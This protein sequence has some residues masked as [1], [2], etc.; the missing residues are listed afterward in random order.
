M[1]NCTNPYTCFDKNIAII[2]GLSTGAQVHS[3]VRTLKSRNETFDTRD[4]GTVHS[5]NVKMNT[6]LKHD[7]ATLFAV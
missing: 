5:M 1:K 7:D 2:R 6:I 4:L 3:N